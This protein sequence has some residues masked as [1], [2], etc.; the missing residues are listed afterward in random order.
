[1]GSE[2]RIWHCRCCG[3]GRCCG[4]FLAQEWSCA[5]GAAEE[6]QVIKSDSTSKAVTSASAPQ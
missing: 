5:A 2:L 3:S 6:T 4:A 1:M